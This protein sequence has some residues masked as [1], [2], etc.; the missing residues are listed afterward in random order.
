[1]GTITVENLKGVVSYEPCVSG[2]ADLQEFRLRRKPN[3]HKAPSLSRLPLLAS[4]YDSR[5]RKTDEVRDEIE[6]EV[7]WA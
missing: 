3:P 2:T 5:A 1:V 4:H 7:D 6:H